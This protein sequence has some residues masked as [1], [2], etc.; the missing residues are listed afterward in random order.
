MSDV[1][2]V[3]QGYFVV[4]FDLNVARRTTSGTVILSA[5]TVPRGQLYMGLLPDTGYQFKGPVWFLCWKCGGFPKALVQIAK[6][7]CGF[8][9][10]VFQKSRSERPFFW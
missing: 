7:N 3:H 1:F 10:A 2:T 5:S 9:V 4:L 6:E 8:L